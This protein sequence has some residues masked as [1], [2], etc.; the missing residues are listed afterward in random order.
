MNIEEM[1]SN[2]SALEDWFA[3]NEQQL[4]ALTELV[5]GKLTSLQRR[6]LVAL[7]TQDVHARD[8]VETLSKFE[9]ASTNDF[10]WV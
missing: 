6:I 2:P 9:V 1:V 5:R 4:Q 10:N 8:I 7:V 3:I